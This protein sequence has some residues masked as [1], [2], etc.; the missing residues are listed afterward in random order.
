VATGGGGLWANGNEVILGGDGQRV[1]DA[2]RDGTTDDPTDP[3][4]IS[5]G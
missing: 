2:S 4:C 3:T 1:A 5:G